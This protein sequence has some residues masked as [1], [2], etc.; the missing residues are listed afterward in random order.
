MNPKTI[1]VIGGSGFLGRYVVRGLAKAGYRLRVIVRQ[2]EAASHLRTAGDVGQ[3]TLESG[4]L[5]L[6]ES[7]IGK[8]EDSH[9]VINLVGVLFESGRQNFINL[10]AQGAEKL[11]KMAKTAGVARFIHVSALGI[12]NAS[13]SQYARTKVLGEK[14]V[15]AAFPEATILRPGVMFGPEDNFFNQ[16]A[17]M[18]ANPLVPCLPLIG[19]GATRFQPVY[20]GDVARAV[21]TCLTQGDAMGQNYELGGPQVLSFKE[22]LEYIL[23]TTGKHARLANVPFGMASMMGAFGEFLPRPPLTR[24][25]VTLLKYDNVVSPD[26]KTF[27][28]LGITPT[29]IDMVVPGYLARFNKGAKAA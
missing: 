11:A 9:A 28:D 5:A 6:P 29:A 25:Q 18:A 15:R 19:G 2:N 1:T 14:A 24:D 7:L 13:G 16:F 4:N 20:V 8:I 3:I 10:H 26:A 21:E 23:R 27:A 17:A 22:I 12:D